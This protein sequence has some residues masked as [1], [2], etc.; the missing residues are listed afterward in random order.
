M[1]LLM[2]CLLSVMTDKKIAQAIVLLNYLFR[3]LLWIL[4][5]NL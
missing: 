2:I 5:E 4:N 3:I 1:V